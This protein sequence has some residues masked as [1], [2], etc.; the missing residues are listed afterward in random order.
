MPKRLLKALG[1]LNPQALI[2]EGFNDA[3]TG[4]CINDH[5][6]LVAQYSTGKCIQILQDEGMSESDAIE[7][8][9]FNTIQAYVGPHG[10]IFWNDWKDDDEE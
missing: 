7:F 5:G 4:I 1:R 3:I 6:N 9:D 2:A 8:M 10:P